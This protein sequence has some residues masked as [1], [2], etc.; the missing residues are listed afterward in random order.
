ME[1]Y[2]KI[3]RRLNGRQRKI[4]QEIKITYYSDISTPKG[5]YL[6]YMHIMYNI[7][8]L[9]C[10]VAAWTKA[11]GDDFWPAKERAFFLSFLHINMCFFSPPLRH[12]N[13]IALLYSMRIFLPNAR[14][15]VRARGSWRY[16]QCCVCRWPLPRSRPTLPRPM[17]SVSVWYISEFFFTL[18]K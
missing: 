14:Q 13:I 7:A 15:C 11:K 3:L 6:Y 8:V 17:V 9:L 2:R 4:L 5:T 12:I 16:M 10:A 18:L 1:K